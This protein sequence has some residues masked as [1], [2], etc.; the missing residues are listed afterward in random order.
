MSHQSPFNQKTFIEWASVNGYQAFFQPST[1]QLPAGTTL[2]QYG[3]IPV[4]TAAEI[5]IPL[6][7]VRPGEQRELYWFS[8]KI[9]S[10]AD[11][12]IRMSLEGNFQYDPLTDS[13]PAGAW[14]T[15]TGYVVSNSKDHTWSGGLIKTKAGEALRLRVFPSNGN[16]GDFYFKFIAFDIP[17]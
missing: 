5:V 16:A 13:F 9:V 3:W 11:Q 15:T 12:P 8:E 7:E 2:N 14:K 4:P 6:V 1:V 17:R 10:T